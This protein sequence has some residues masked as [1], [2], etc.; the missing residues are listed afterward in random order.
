[1][2]HISSY[3]ISNIPNTFIDNYNNFRNKK[4][5]K[6]EPFIMH[7]M[8]NKQQGSIKSTGNFLRWNFLQKHLIV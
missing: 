4:K 5:T 3:H 1:M 8:L 2:T 7:Y 6:M